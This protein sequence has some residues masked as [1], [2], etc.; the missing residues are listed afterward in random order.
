MAEQLPFQFADP[1]DPRIA[2]YLERTRDSVYSPEV[3]QS[4]TARVWPVSTT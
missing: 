1:L 2:D 3:R 4:I